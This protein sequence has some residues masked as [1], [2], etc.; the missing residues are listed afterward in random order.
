[1]LLKAGEI[2]ALR[3][4]TFHNLYFFNTFAEK[5]RDKIKKGII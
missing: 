3:L 1:H 5:I 2:T 4:I